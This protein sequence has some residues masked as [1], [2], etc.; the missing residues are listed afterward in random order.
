MRR[1]LAVAVRGLTGGRPLLSTCVVST[2]VGTA[3]L[4]SS[5]VDVWWVLPLLMLAVLSSRL[6]RRGR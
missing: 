4:Q 5:G 6:R 3:G 1:H 2:A